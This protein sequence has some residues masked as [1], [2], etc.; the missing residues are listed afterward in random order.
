MAGEWR[1]LAQQKVNQKEGISPPSVDQPS[2]ST[3]AS[4]RDVAAQ[5]QAEK[6]QPAPTEEKEMGIADIFTGA[7][8]IAETP[9][10]GTAPEFAQTEEYLN[11]TALQLGMLSTF[12]EQAQK[13]MIQ[14]AIPEAEFVRTGDGSTF[15][16]IPDES[17]KKV[18]S[19]LNRP[20]FS[21]QD[22]L[23]AG[24][25]LMAFIPSARLANLGSTLARKVG[26][27]ALGG[28]ATEQA[29]QETGMSLGREER[30]PAATA[31]AGVTG[32]AA[33]AI[34]P[35]VQGTRA[36]L[37]ARRAGV[38]RSALGQIEEPVRQAREAAGGLEAVTGQ[39]VGLFQGQQTLTPSDLIRQRI[40]P[41]LQASSRHAADMLENQN[42]EVFE[43]TNR[44]IQT[45]APDQVVETGAHRFRDAAQRARD[46]RVVAR[47]EASSPIYKQ[48]FRRQR[49]GHTPL[50]DTEVLQ[51]KINGIIRGN[52]AGGQVANSLETVGRRI[53]DAAGDL[54]RLQSAKLE[55][56]NMIEGRG[57]NALGRTTR[58]ALTDIKNDLVDLMVDQSPSYRA[59]RDEFI[60]LTPAVEALDNS[61]VGRIANIPDDQLKNVASK[62][63]DP[64]EIN[65]T[66]LRNAQQVISDVDPGAWDDIVRVELE[67]RMGGLR[68][69]LTESGDE[70]AANIPGQINRAL[71][72]NAKNRQVFMSA[73]NPEQRQNFRYLE[74]VIRRSMRGRAAGSP[75]TPFKEALDKMRGVA[76]VLRDTIF[77]P[78]STL[79][80]IGE[81]TLFDSRVSSLSRLV[82]DPQW[83]PQMNQL[84]ALNPNSPASARAMMQNLRMIGED[85]EGETE[86]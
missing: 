42:R 66:V 47:S 59:A 84:R 22:F 76:G 1:E 31:L 35:A 67:R 63:F 81:Q 28:A 26:L 60:R 3:G 70:V 12:D 25:Q 56:D 2:V 44:L 71:F 8:R 83:R 75:T 20:G 11:N 43:A 51:N 78:V 50:L 40:L 9:E 7:E 53:D 32:G 36:W 69:F 86:K 85:S 6:E 80:D 16:D 38:E 18:R 46:V 34:V 21:E 5:R 79:Q 23:T 48:A 29:L 14:E 61:L 24:A 30:D 58:R 57:D 62:I 41:Q 4:W 54:Q 82:F 17:G 15:I 45:I 72:G 19:V 68:N 37:R 74:T 13:E 39:R 77:R 49:Q 10:L 27:G 65:P 55:I 52:S 64:K 33:E 73:L